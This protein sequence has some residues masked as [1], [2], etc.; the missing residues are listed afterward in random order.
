MRHD[1]GL[2]ASHPVRYILGVEEGYPPLAWP[3]VANST[4]KLDLGCSRL[5]N[6]E[7]AEWI[8]CASRPSGPTLWRELK[9]RTA[10]QIRWQLIHSHFHTENEALAF[11]GYAEVSNV[12]KNEATN[13]P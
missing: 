12:W 8:G 10:N 9:C 3:K 7:Q 4:A 11:I 13:H 1:S 6:G 2:A 5:L